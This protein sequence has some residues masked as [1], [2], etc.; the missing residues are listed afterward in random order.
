MHG[1]D[2][3]RCPVGASLLHLGI[4][5]V[6][7]LAAVLT[8][9][10]SLLHSLLSSQPWVL[11]PCSS[12]VALCSGPVLWLVPGPLLGLVPRLVPCL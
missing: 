8:G 3:T 10:Y 1:L 7:A 11:V 4:R 12:A 2:S 9:Y 6:R 5:L